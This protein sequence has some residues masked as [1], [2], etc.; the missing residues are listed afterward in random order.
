MLPTEFNRRTSRSNSFGDHARARDNVR[1][2][3]TVRQ[4]D[5]DTPIATEVARAGQHEVPE[6]SQPG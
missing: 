1:D 6:P 2:R 3:T 5:P 4:L